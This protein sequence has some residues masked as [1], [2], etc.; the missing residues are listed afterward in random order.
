MSTEYDTTVI[1]SSSVAEITDIVMERIFFNIAT[2]I[3]LGFVAFAISNS[4]WNYIPIGW[5]DTD[6]KTRSGLI[7]Y[8]DCKTGVQYLSTTNSAPTVRLDMSG[9]PVV[10]FTGCQ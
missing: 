4:V 2:W 3:F 6:G 1:E 5:D 8:T 10:D 7:P 9:K